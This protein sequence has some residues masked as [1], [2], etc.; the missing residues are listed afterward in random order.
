MASRFVTSPTSDAPGTRTTVRGR[1]RLRSMSEQQVRAY[2]MARDV[3]RCI[4]RNCTLAIA[5]TDRPPEHGDRM[6]SMHHP[7][8]DNP[9]AAAGRTTQP[10][11]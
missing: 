3:V 8:R 5:P 7:K 4:Q 6:R 9:Q 1:G 10:E 11:A 2:L